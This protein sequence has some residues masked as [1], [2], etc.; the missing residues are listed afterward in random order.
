MRKPRQHWDIVVLGD[1][2]YD[3]YLLAENACVMRPAGSAFNMG[4]GLGASRASA[5]LVA[6]IATRFDRAPLTMFRRM[7]ITIHE[8]ALDTDLDQLFVFDFR[9]GATD[10]P[11]FLGTVSSQTYEP[12]LFQDL[13][14]SQYIVHVGTM[15]PPRARRAIELI[16]QRDRAALISG[17][18]YSE[19]LRRDPDTYAKLLGACR[20]LFF[21]RVE[22]NLAVRAIGLSTI[23]ADR[24][25]I[26]TAGQSGATLLVDGTPVFHYHPRPVAAIC[27]VGAGDVLIGAF[28]GAF[29]QTR[30]P[31][32]SLA[33][34]CEV[35]SR[36]TIDYGVERCLDSLADFRD[37]TDV[38]SLIGRESMRVPTLVGEELTVTAVGNDEAYVEATGL[39][40][41]R[42]GELLLVKKSAGTELRRGVL[43]VP[44]GKLNPGESPED[45][46]R[47]ELKEETS[48]EARAL[49][50]LSVFVYRDEA[51]SRVYKFH[52]FLVTPGEGYGVP[53]DDVSELVWVP[54]DRLDRSML[55]DLTWA[56]WLLMRI[57]ELV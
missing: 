9:N 48:L 4:C 22:F 15:P 8:Q 39:F 56:Q 40:V 31:S 43:Y 36:S 28:L 25:V 12:H 17:N 18:V 27:V 53:G 2:G 54:F 55:F 5:T 16:E 34:A 7:L 35:A 42:S 33:F 1:V 21:N 6:T 49:R 38:R 20:I 41:V 29:A 32:I 46:A 14:S 24:I 23:C 11:S 44:G 57:G 51:R 26:V 50:S 52:Q 37:P 30:D 47:R 10:E 13:I 45:C 19:Y 3:A